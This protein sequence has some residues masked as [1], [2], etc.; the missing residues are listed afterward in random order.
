MSNHYAALRDAGWY[1]RPDV[2]KLKVLHV[3]NQN[4][5]ACCSGVPLDEKSAQ[6]LDDVPPAL[7]CC[8]RACAKHWEAI[9]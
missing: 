7:R 5:F 8:R 9:G 2:Y 1:N 4:M 3:A 6:K